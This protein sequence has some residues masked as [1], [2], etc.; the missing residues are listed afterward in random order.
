MANVTFETCMAPKDE[1]DGDF[2]KGLFENRPTKIISALFSALFAI[3]ILPLL[4]TIVW[5]EKNGSNQKRT[6]LDKLVSTVCWTC[7]GWYLIIQNIDLIRYFSGPLSD[8]LCIFQLYFKNAIFCQFIFIFAAIAVARYVFI[9]HLKNPAAFNDDFWSWFIN[10]WTIFSSVFLQIF[11]ALLPGRRT[12]Y[13]YICSGRNPSLDQNIPLKNFTYI[14]VLFLIIVILYI[15]IGVRIYLYKRGCAEIE[16][17]EKNMKENLADFAANAAIVL[18]VL[19]NVLL[20]YKINTI[21]IKDF[22][23]Y[24]NYLYEYFYRMISPN[25][26]VFIVVL[27]HFFRHP[28]LTSVLRTK[29]SDMANAIAD[30]INSLYPF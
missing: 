8:G 29:L 22:N 17:K 25:I 30:K 13:F 23:C 12:L 10:I 21:E 6:L 5:F 9:F 27:L 26:F 28:K 3:I 16:A 18:M 14:I 24:P 2:F 19:I 1:A 11:M 4:Y 15:F 7:I 20:S